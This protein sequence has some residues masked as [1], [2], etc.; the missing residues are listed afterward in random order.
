MSCSGTFKLCVDQIE[1][2]LKVF[3]P[4]NQI[5]STYTSLSMLI[6]NGN[7]IATNP[8]QYNGT[9]LEVAPV[10]PQH[11]SISLNYTLL[12]ISNLHGPVSFILTDETNTQ[13]INGPNYGTKIADSIVLPSATTTTSALMVPT[14]VVSSTPVPSSGYNEWNA[15][16]ITV[17]V[18]ASLLLFT[19]II[20]GYLVQR[21]KKQEPV[22]TPYAISLIKGEVDL[23]IQENSRNSTHR[24]TIEIQEEPVIVQVTRNNSISTQ[25]YSISDSS[26]ELPAAESLDSQSFKSFPS[27]TMK[28]SR[29]SLSFK[30]ARS[31][32]FKSVP[33][34]DYE[35]EEEIDIPTDVVRPSNMFQ[36][37]R[38]ST[39]SD[40]TIKH[41]K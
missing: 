29:S 3:Y 25:Y 1:N 5:P 39:S 2:P 10:V 24:R 13:C 21:K 33:D 31:V 30:S 6:V 40:D 12:D 26:S 28:S 27:Q 36:D 17:V 18:L 38:K 9:L 19:V 34:Q 23:L 4:V 41:N 37:D 35:S 7:L 14:S 16:L 32:S 8:C 22:L 11:W 15:L 20:V